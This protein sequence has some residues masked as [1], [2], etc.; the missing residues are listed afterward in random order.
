VAGGDEW[1]NFVGEK[2]REVLAQVEVL[3]LGFIW[4]GQK[5]SMC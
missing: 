4:R 1:R 2:G 5:G 3:K